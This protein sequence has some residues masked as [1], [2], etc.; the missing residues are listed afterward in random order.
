M[1]HYYDFGYF[2][3]RKDSGSIQIT[4]TEKLD[5]NDIDECVNYALKNNMLEEDY[6]D[7]IIYIEELTESDAKDM[8][9]DIS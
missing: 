4:T 7:N 6:A 2:F 3:N 8:G 9:F 1:K 5:T